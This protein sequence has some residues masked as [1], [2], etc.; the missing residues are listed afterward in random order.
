MMTKNK[1]AKL[2]AIDLTD[3]RKTNNEINLDSACSTYVDNVEGETMQSAAKTMEIFIG[4]GQIGEK[5]LGSFDLGT[6]HMNK[7]IK[8][9]IPE[10]LA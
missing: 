4:L 7:C 9:W 6:Q 1:L 10:F 2:I 3:Y 5:K 8:H